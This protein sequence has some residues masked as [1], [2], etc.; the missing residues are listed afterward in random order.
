MQAIEVHLCQAISPSSHLALSTYLREL[1]LALNAHDSLSVHVYAL[2]PT[3]P[4]LERENV[5]TT[6]IEGSPYSLIGQMRYFRTL[7]RV[8]RERL[9]GARDEVL[10]CL[11]PNSSL[12]AASDMKRRLHESL[13]VLYDVRSPW[14]EMSLERISIPRIL[15]S[16]YKESLYALEGHLGRSV[17]RW[18]F[19]TE[20]LRNWYGLKVAIPPHRAFVSPS[21]VD[22]KAFSRAKGADLRARFSISDGSMLIG[23]VGAMTAIRRLDVLI[24]AVGYLRAKGRDATL[25]LVGDGDDRP[26]LE[27]M[28]HDQALSRHIL[29]TGKVAPDVVPEFIAAL[30][31]CVSHLPDLFLFRVSFPLK[32][33]EYRAANKPVVASNVECHRRLAAE[34]GL[35]LYTWNSSEQ[36]AEAIQ[37]ATQTPVEEVD[38]SPYSW[39]SIAQGFLEQYIDISRA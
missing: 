35:L 22:V 12:A 8:L 21:G 2:G 10:H 4:A 29:F 7:R 17:D 16:A 11:Y 13:R 27:R 34:L 37:R 6:L 24:E 9:L 15:R 33:L 20:S 5:D 18:S 14:I 32:I 26:R 38:L 30:D 1:A 28:T 39:D 31:V 23:Y 3:S 36:L 25:L 19:I